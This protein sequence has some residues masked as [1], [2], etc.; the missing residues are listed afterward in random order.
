MT[1]QPP[2]KDNIE[3]IISACLEQAEN[4]LRASKTILEKESLP[5]IAYHLATL[6]LEEVGK[7]SL[8]RVN[9]IVGSETSKRH[10]EKGSDDH[11]KKLFWALWSPSFGHE[12]ITN[13]QIT[14]FKGLANHIHE[15]RLQTLYVPTNEEELVRYKQSV[16]IKEVENLISVAGVTLDMER[17]YKPKDEKDITEEDKKDLAWFLQATNDSENR[18][19]MFSKKSMEKLVQ[20]KHTANWIRWMRLEFEKADLEA[21]ALLQKE[22][23]RKKPDENEA[24]K[25]KW[26]MKIRFY[27]NSHSIRPGILNWWNDKL[28]FLRLFPVKDKKE[29]ICEITLPKQILM[30]A[31][32]L[33]N[34]GIAR[35]FI[36]ALNIATRG[37]FWWYLPEQVNEYYES[38]EDLENKSNKVGSEISPSL[39][40]NW[41]RKEEA[42]SEN[43]L[44][45]TLMSFGMIPPSHTEGKHI[46]FDHYLTGLAFLSKTDVHMQFEANSFQE[47]YEC[48][49]HAMILYGD[50]K[51]KEPLEDALQRVFAKLFDDPNLWKVYFDLGKK[52]SGPNF[53]FPKGITLSQAGEMKLICDTYFI[54]KFRELNNKQ[55]LEN[56]VNSTISP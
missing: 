34:L 46:P 27:T 4:L 1:N 55:R 41:S 47:F 8:L 51:E 22:L 13:A 15:K 53:S 56:N 31:I 28:N 20:L 49:K 17:R 14:T 52:F 3:S 37:Y 30:Q 6:A 25:P 21:Q 23:A 18:R 48:L 19:Y 40:I 36:V 24:N 39:Q 38:L 2:K 45:R 10:L 16:D 12:L 35:R 33:T 42:L 5:S 29:L 50:W 44:K 54:N 43:D 26:K 11:V 7:V 32:W 9:Q